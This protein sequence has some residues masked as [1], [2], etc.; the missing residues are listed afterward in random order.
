MPVQTRNMAN[1][2]EN[3]PLPNPPSFYAPLLW[4]FS[5]VLALIRCPEKVTVPKLD[6]LSGPLPLFDTI[7][8]FVASLRSFLLAYAV[9]Y[10]LHDENS[11]YPAWGRGK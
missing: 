2:A 4:P 11:P 10:V 9:V 3:L 5:Y 1:Q 8:S 6:S 7:F